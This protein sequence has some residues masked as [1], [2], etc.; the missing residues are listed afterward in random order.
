LAAVIVVELF[1][2]VSQNWSHRP[3]LGT[4]IIGGILGS[5]C[6]LIHRDQNSE[7]TTLGWLE[8]EER[9]DIDKHKEDFAILNDNDLLSEIDVV[10][11]FMLHYSLKMKCLI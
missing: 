4:N 10:N 11:S 8:D 6:E 7:Q 1:A 2:L 5:S 9:S 3:D